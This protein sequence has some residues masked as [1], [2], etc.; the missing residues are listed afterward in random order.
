MAPIVP[1]SKTASQYTFPCSR[2]SS[3]ARSSRSTAAT[4]ASAAAM[5]PAARSSI[6]RAAHP[7]KARR[8]AATAPSSWAGDAAGASKTTSAG[9]TGLV[10]A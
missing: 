8:A 1:A 10:T 3:R 2:D 7:G 6:L 4:P 5:T 9:R